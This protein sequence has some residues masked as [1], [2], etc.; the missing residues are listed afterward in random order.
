MN[1]KL[2]RPINLQVDNSG[3][4][5]RKIRHLRILA[6]TTAVATYA[7]IVL[8][9]TVR[10]TNSGMGCPSWPLCAGHVGPIYEFHPL[11]EQSHRYLASVVTILIISVAILVWRL[12]SSV[13]HM[14][15]AVKLG[16]A[17]IVV[18]IILGAITVLAHNAPPTVAIHLFVALF[19]LAIVTVIAFLSFIAPDQEW[20]L[21]RYPT[22]LMW[23]S[24][25]GLFLV[26]ISGSLVVNGGASRACPSWPLCSSKAPMPLVV[27]Q[28]LH[29]SLVLIATIL[30]VTA[31]I[32][33][34]VRTQSSNGMKVVLVLGLVMLMAQI[35]LGAIDAMSS[36]PAVLAD[37]HL[38][39]AAGIWV[40]EIVSLSFSARKNIPAIGQL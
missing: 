29:R 34:L 33:L 22:K 2:A 8:G 19:F 18:Q 37:L 5:K 6:V 26:F 30:V 31:F 36:A 23:S 25:V 10:V 11:L 15:G 38:V 28:L 27:L 16:L 35:I 9:S 7:L 13:Y 3:L 24:V 4:L 12:G 21:R 17:M 39:F 20:S 1:E 40:I 14:R 32:S